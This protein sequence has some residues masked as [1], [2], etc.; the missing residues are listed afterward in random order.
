M[1]IVNLKNLGE[2]IKER[3]EF[4]QYSQKDLAELT[5]IS[6]RTIR[7]IEQGSGSSKIKYWLKILEVLG[8]EITIQYKPISNET[9]E[10][11]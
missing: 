7:I 8:L 2:K 9:R 5:Q 10:S 11:L 4:L 1:N 3:R 6:E